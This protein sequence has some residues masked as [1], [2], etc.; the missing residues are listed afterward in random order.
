MVACDVRRPAPPG[1]G[2]RSRAPGAGSH[3][4]MVALQLALG[5][6]LLTSQPTTD[7]EVFRWSFLPT[8]DMFRFVLTPPAKIESSAKRYKLK[9]QGPLGSGTLS[10]LGSLP[11]PAAGVSWEVPTLPAGP[12][13]LSLYLLDP[14]NNSVAE[15]IDSFNRTIQTWEGTK[16]GRDD[17]V[18][19]MVIPP[20][21][22]IQL[23]APQGSGDAL[24]SLGFLGKSVAIDNATGLWGQVEATPA[25]TPRLQRVCTACKTAPAISLLAGPME[26]VVVSSGVSHSSRGSAVGPMETMEVSTTGNLAYTAATWTIGPL[27]GRTNAT[28]VSSE[29]SKYSH[30]SL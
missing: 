3:E 19:G 11:T 29:P 22:P 18:Y 16:L 13:T 26:L 2:A 12:Y 8:V 25:M 27:S 6:A 9:L 15:Y 4:A 1:A 17:L 10:T 7:F 21:T 20:Y 30:G 5:V 28:Y 23:Q 14:H 24:V